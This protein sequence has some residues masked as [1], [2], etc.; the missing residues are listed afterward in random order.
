M[1]NTKLRR[2]EMIIDY[3]KL[4]W[5][6]PR[7]GE[8]IIENGYKPFRQTPKGW[9]NSFIGYAIQYPVTP[10]GFDRICIGFSIIMSSL[11]DSAFANINYDL[12]IHG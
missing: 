7:R 12:G 10:S 11:R 1:K 8:M 4:S 6:K 9:Q 5:F 3:R 2:N